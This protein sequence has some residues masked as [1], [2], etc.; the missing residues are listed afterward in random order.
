MFRETQG[1]D[2]QR[3]NYDLHSLLVV[4]EASWRNCY[5]T[6]FTTPGPLT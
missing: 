3:Y 1:P 2:M 6:S 5:S 4:G